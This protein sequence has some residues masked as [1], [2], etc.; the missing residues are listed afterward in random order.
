M[1]YVI[2]R[3]WLL[4]A[5]VALAGCG[6]GVEYGARGEHAAPSARMEVE[7]APRA[8]VEG[9]PMTVEVDSIPLASEL[10][11][12]MRGYA[13]WTIPRGSDK[14][15]LMG[16]LDYDRDAREGQLHT[17]TPYAAQTVIV[18]AE[19]SETPSAPSGTVIARRT[20]EHEP[21]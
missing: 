5:G 2:D 14:P 3:G 8:S 13:V 4:A 11:E 17:T 18:T 6:G 20:V 21:S 16:F 9:F 7:M 12:G 19:R 15:A 10:E 1:R